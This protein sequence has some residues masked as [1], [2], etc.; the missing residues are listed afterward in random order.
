MNRNAVTVGAAGL[1]VVA[2]AVAVLAAATAV[3]AAAAVLLGDR[4]AKYREEGRLSDA[5]AAA[6]DRTRRA[7]EWAEARRGHGDDPVGG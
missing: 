2:S 4:W 7:V 5:A 6:V 3:A 1:A